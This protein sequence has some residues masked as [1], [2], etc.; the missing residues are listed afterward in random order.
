M[1]ASLF[2]GGRFLEAGFDAG[3]GVEIIPEPVTDEVEAEHGEHDG[4]RGKQDEMRGVEQV[5][6]AVVEHRSPACR[7]RR[8]AEPEETHGGF[9]EDGSG[10]ADGGLHNYGL[11]NI[12]ENV[13]DNNSQIGG[14]EGTGGFDEF[15]FASGENLSANHARVTDPSAEGEREDEVE[16]A[17]A[18]EGDEGDGQQN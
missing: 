18:A 15:A 2:S 17:G 10:H 12:R 5:G 14:A 8:D 4:E 7:G 3:A 16:D 1:T 6:A 9:G 13:A 11:N